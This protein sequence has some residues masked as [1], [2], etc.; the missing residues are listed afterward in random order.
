MP[1]S[2]EQITTV[3]EH[4]NDG[5][6]IV[7]RERRILYWNY[8]AER[9]SGYSSEQVIGRFCMDNILMHVDQA[10][11]WLCHNGCPLSA[12]I[13]DGDT[14]EAQVYLH[15]AGGHRVSV[16]VRVIPLYDGENVWGAVEIFSENLTLSAAMEQIAALQRDVMLDPLT[17]MGSRRVARKRLEM[18]MQKWCDHQ[19]QF[20]LLMI[21]I[22]FFKRVNDGFGHAAGDEVLRMVSRSIL[23][24]LG[25]LDYAGRWGGEEF[26]VIINDASAET[27]AGTAERL[28]VLVERSHF[29]LAQNEGAPPQDLWVTIS[30]GGAWCGAADSINGLLEIADRRLYQSKAAGRNRVTI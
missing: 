26:I 11:C 5:A 25:L 23:N 14:H 17:G 18:A 21:D 3:L 19:S 24:G 16:N 9:I 8:A 22:D 27:L 7:D 30:I 20:G 10:G 15:H 28:R 29:V 4:V 6:Y 12:T 1:P 2:L 13:H